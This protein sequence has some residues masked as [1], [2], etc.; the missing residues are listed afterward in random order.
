MPTHLILSSQVDKLWAAELAQQLQND[1]IQCRVEAIYAARP[2]PQVVQHHLKEIQHLLVIVSPETA[3]GDTTEACEAWWQ[4]AIN[5]GVNVTPLVVPH[6]PAGAKHWMP[7]EL[8]QHQP[9]LFVEKD[10]YPQLVARLKEPFN[11]L[12]TT[13]RLNAPQ[14]LTDDTATIEPTVVNA[15]QAPAPPAAAPEPLPD[16]TLEPPRMGFFYYLISIIGGL[17][18]VVMIWF[19]AIQETSSEDSP[20]LLWLGGVALVVS[21]LFTLGRIEVNKRQRRRYV[22]QKYT[23]AQG[24]ARSAIKPP[25]YVE[26][27]E[28]TIP[29][30]RGLVWEV[31]G[32]SFSIGKD[33]TCDLPLSGQKYLEDRIALIYFEEGLYYLENISQQTVITLVDRRLTPS[34]VAA[35]TNGDMIQ[36]PE[37]LLQF[38]FDT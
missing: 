32:E 19:A 28:S 23:Q 25:I 38:R 14:T 1:Q 4:T 22:E 18:L 37:T 10:A 17:T 20:I 7:F 33:Y 34:T 6:A 12:P 9:I 15:P 27:I 11:A 21:A 2:T 31:R 8:Q 13:N 35:V 26:V 36:I 16:L 30:L 29:Q 24:Y 3:L 5:Q